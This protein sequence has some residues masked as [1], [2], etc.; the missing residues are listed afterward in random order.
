MDMHGHTKE[1][2]LRAR[3]ALKDSRRSRTANGRPQSHE[4]APVK[5]PRTDPPAEVY[6]VRDLLV[7]I[8]ADAGLENGEK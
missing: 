6:T 8:R 1:S 3:K 4:P 2:A 7:G 5:S